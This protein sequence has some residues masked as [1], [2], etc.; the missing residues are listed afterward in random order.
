MRS[1]PATWRKRIGFQVLSRRSEKVD[2]YEIKIAQ[3]QGAFPEP[4]WPSRSLDELL[5]VT[6]NTPQ[7][8]GSQVL[9]STFPSAC[10]FCIQK[11]Q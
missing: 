5:E 9:R 8:K 1:R 6:F 10:F 3:D 11:S 7:V 4:E 2:R